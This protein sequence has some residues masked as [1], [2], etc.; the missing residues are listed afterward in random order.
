MLADKRY[1]ASHGSY[2]KIQ[3]QISVELHKFCRDHKYPN[4]P[5]YATL[6]RI[7]GMYKVSDVAPYA[8]ANRRLSI[9]NKATEKRYYELKKENENLR[10]KIAEI[11]EL[12]KKSL[13]TKIEEFTS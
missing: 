5:L 9:V 1:G 6:D 4:E 11:E 2:G 3:A 13:D 7:V 10:K 12:M 8:E